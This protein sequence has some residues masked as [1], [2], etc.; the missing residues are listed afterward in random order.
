MSQWINTDFEDYD[1]FNRRKPVRLLN[2]YRNGKIGIGN[3]DENAIALHALVLQL[4]ANA[5]FK[6]IPS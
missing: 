4:V 1:Y 2:F 6:C 3:I 5:D